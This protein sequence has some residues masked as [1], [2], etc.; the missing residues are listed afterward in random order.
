MN[1]QLVSGNKLIE[2]KN[3]IKVLQDLISNTQSSIQNQ[4][5]AHDRRRW[6][7]TREPMKAAEFLSLF[8]NA[9]VDSDFVAEN[10]EIATKQTDLSTAIAALRPNDQSGELYGKVSAIKVRIEELQRKKQSAIDTYARLKIKPDR[11]LT[12]VEFLQ[13]YQAPTFATENTAITAAQTECNKLD[14]F[15][16]SGPYPQYPAQYDIDQLSGTAV[17]P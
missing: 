1:M 15:L 14:A 16:K 2:A 8:P 6:A 13:M 10:A 12:E 4:R 5:D 3:R 7:A 9:P 11:P 17:S